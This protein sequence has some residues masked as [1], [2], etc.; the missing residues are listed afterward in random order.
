MKP[1]FSSRH[2]VISSFERFDETEEK[3]RAL[4]F[5]EEMKGYVPDLS[6]IES[7][8]D[9]REPFV[10][11]LLWFVNAVP[12]TEQYRDTVATAHGRMRKLLVLNEQD[13]PAG[14]P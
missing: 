14:N 11:F 9:R 13:H 12:K 5:P 1:K 4:P 2:Q 8:A 10:L 6:K 3:L 7:V